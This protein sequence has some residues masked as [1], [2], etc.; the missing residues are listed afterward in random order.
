MGTWAT[1]EGVF[2]PGSRFLSHSGLRGVNKQ[3]DKLEPAGGV[4]GGSVGRTEAT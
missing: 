1:R 4:R 3:M 2:G